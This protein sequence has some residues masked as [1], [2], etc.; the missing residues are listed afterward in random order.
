MPE[1]TYT[2]RPPLS[3]MTDAEVRALGF[4]N[5]QI[6]DVLRGS[7][8]PDAMPEYHLDIT[9]ATGSGPTYTVNLA[10][11]NAMSDGLTK[12]KIGDKLIIGDDIDNSTGGAKQWY[13]YDIIGITL[14]AFASAMTVTVKYVIDSASG[15]DVNPNTLHYE[16]DAYGGSVDVNIIARELNPQFMLG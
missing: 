9:G 14:P 1:Q 10:Y 11:D 16:Y 15:G 4:H 12:I 2:H 13:R 8:D 6:F 5:Y 3:Y 7:G